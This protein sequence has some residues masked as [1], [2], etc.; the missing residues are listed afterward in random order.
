MQ[1]TTNKV[2]IVESML[3]QATVSLLSSAQ[4]V[5][6]KSQVGGRDL[7]YFEPKW[8]S[9]KMSTIK[10]NQTT[11]VLGILKYIYTINISKLYLVSDEYILNLGGIGNLF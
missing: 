2:S 9:S 6:L 7:I 11:S 5:I 3:K 4:A 8:S 1:N 10:K